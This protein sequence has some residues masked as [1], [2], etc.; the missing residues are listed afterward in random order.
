M[1]DTPTLLAPTRA[2]FERQILWLLSDATDT[3][4]LS[5]GSLSIVDHDHLVIE[6]SQL[7]GPARV[8]PYRIPLNE[9]LSSLALE[10]DDVVYWDDTAHDK[11]AQQSLHVKEFGLRSYIGRAFPADGYRWVLGFAANEPHAFSQPERDYVE[12]L[13]W[14]I[15][16]LIELRSSYVGHIHERRMAVASRRIRSLWEVATRYDLDHRSKAFEVLAVGARE[17]GLEFGSAARVVDGRLHFE[18]LQPQDTVTDDVLISD[19]LFSVVLRTEKTSA[20]SDTLTDP[21]VR[22][23]ARVSRDGIRAF[24]G[25][26]FAVN[27]E[28]Y[29]LGFYAR[30]PRS[31]AFEQDDFAFMEVLAAFFSWV[32]TESRQSQ[33]IAY[34]AYHDGLTG[35]L[36]RSAFMEHLENLVHV[37]RRTG[38][39][40]CVAYVDLDGFKAINDSL[41]HVTADAVLK[42]A[43]LCLRAGLRDI[44]VVGRVGGD[45]FALALPGLPPLAATKVTERVMKSLSS[46]TLH[47]K[48]FGL[49]ASIGVTC[50]SKSGGETADILLRQADAAMYHAKRIG[51]ANVHFYDD[52]IAADVDRRDRIVRGL[53]SALDDARLVLHYQPVVNLRSGRVSGAEALVRWRNG[54]LVMPDQFIDIAETSGLMDELGDWVLGASLWQ[55]RLWAQRYGDLRMSVNVS[56]VQLRSGLFFESLKQGFE[57][58]GAPSHLLDLEVTES[59][60]VRDPNST[61]KT[62]RSCRS[63]GAQVFLDDFG[64]RY[65]TLSHLKVLPFDGIKIDRT[66][67]EGLPEDHNDA[68]IVKAIIALSSE[69]QLR[70]IAEGIESPE[71][72]AWLVDMG[73]DFG[74]GYYVAR[75]M[76]AE[77]FEQWMD[78]GHRRSMSPVSA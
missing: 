58:S 75:P 21:A 52:R 60:A 31:E 29:V 36:N 53:R 4:G 27:D 2:A 57:R 8:R 33:N 30:T 34:L 72:L 26:P 32:L 71:Q 20:W 46:A 76:P 1:D 9:T 12:H 65:S 78:D 13:S 59:F 6:Y 44:D 66:F 69:L 49:T 41:G 56:P 74:Q 73:C 45:E 42:E 70:V 16:A 43:A 54:N 7:L 61:A 47:G 38:E 64:T 67:V 15:A 51:A 25:S 40:L 50:Y 37:H 55:M 48:E 10:R 68:A 35:L 28:R 23:L 39:P 77:Q 18:F 63:L 11:R 62:L 22:E 5:G 14:I 24:I 17:L 19:T 3:L